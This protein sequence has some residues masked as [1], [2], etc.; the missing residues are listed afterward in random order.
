MKSSPCPLQPTGKPSV[1][2]SYF[3]ED[4][5]ASSPSQQER[6]LLETSGQHPPRVG[7]PSKPL[8][9][10]VSFQ[11]HSEPQ[12]HGGGGGGIEL[13]NSVK[14]TCRKGDGIY[15]DRVTRLFLETYSEQNSYPSFPQTAS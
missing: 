4:S 15:R 9:G 7:A 11:P 6:F 3:L 2:V 13:S 5:V 1:V 14:A 12:T 10:I 8:E